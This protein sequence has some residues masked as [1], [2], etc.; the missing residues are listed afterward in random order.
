MSLKRLLLVLAGSAALAWLLFYVCLIA[1]WVLAEQPMPDWAR[2]SAQSGDI[3]TVVL[4]LLAWGMPCLITGLLLG[5]CLRQNALQ[6]AVLTGLLILLYLVLNP[7]SHRALAGAELL[8]WLGHFLMRYNE[9]CY[10][11]LALPL[12]AWL[13]MRLRAA[14]TPAAA[15]A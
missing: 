6:V 7:L 10:P 12:G 11:L 8:R 14:R 13:G 2:Q 9:V 4:K 1:L 3:Y 15:M 5:S